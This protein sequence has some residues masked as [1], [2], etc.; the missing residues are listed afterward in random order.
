MHS[1]KRRS[2]A[3]LQFSSFSAQKRSVHPNSENWFLPISSAQTARST[4]KAALIL[5]DWGRILPDRSKKW[6][7]KKIWWQRWSL[8]FF[9]ACLSF[10]SR[11]AHIE[12]AKLPS[13]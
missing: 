6:N 11:S 1:T 12:C 13:T 9:H 2:F 7:N 5:G 8:W 4:F 3:N 10:L